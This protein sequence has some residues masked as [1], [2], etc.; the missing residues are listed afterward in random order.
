MLQ[1]LKLLVIKEKCVALGTFWRLG[2]FRGAT[3]SIQ[4]LFR[5]G[6]E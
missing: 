3:H 5:G 4:S 1:N 2:Y 6:I